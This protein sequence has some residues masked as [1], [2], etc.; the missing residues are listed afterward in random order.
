[1][2]LTSWKNDKKGGKITKYDIKIGKN[3]LSQTELEDLNRLVSMYLDW[4]E[5]FARRQIP[6]TMKN[7]MVS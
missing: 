6:M 5:N 2:G 7:W 4:A 3:Y 1:M